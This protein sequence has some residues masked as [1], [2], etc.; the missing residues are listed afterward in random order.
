MAL[1][2]LKVQ[3]EAN[4]GVQSFPMSVVR[5]EYGAGRLGIHVRSGISKELD[6]LGLGHYPH[7]L[8]D[9][10]YEIV[11]LYKRGSRVADIIN[12]VLRP[13]DEGDQEIREVSS[14]EATEVLARVREMVCP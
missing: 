2:D 8:P 10:Q 13:G 14:G 4:G 6:G 3:V 5:D 12:A 1:E 7:V 9:S 11:R